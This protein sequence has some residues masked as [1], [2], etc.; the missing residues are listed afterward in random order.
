MLEKKTDN[1]QPELF[2]LPKT[3]IEVDDF[4]DENGKKKGRI[5]TG[6]TR[7]QINKLGKN[8]SKRRSG[9]ASWPNEY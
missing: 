6:M 7:D 9:D 3:R 4:L 2:E 1:L 5:P 8:K